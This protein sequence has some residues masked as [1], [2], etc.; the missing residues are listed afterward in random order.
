MKKY[1]GLLVVVVMAVSLV[2]CA[3][4]R[5]GEGMGPGTGAAAAFARIFGEN[6]SFSATAVMNVKGKGDDR[7]MQMKY[8]M[9]DGAVRMNLDMAQM[10]GGM[11][12][13]ALARMKQMGM[14]HYAAIVHPGTDTAPMMIYPGL[15]AY[16][17]VQVRNKGTKGTPKI[18]KT[19]IGTDKID[20]HPCD[21]YK[22]T[23]TQP[24][25]GS[26]DMTE[27]QAT[28]LKNFP[29][30]LELAARNSVTTI[31]YTDID[32]SKPDAS[33]FE[34]PAGYTRYD[35]MRALMMSQV[36]KMMGGMMGGGH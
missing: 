14:D 26:Q 27:W 25:G 30:Q 22:I 33:L 35:S 23:I 21:K 28:D 19:K 18:E 2:P 24:G 20:G 11:P 16:V 13:E 8:F 34:V 3:E 10:G 9:R 12:P 32:Q 31:R 5:G 1:L 7:T 6:S 29:I 4:A 36:G 15:K 17:E